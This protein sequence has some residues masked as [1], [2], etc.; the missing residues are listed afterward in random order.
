MIS[1]FSLSL[2]L[3]ILK[4]YAW[5]SAL[6][7]IFYILVLWILT[8]FT[9]FIPQNFFFITLIVLFLFGFVGSIAILIFVLLAV[10]KPL[11]SSVKKIEYLAKHSS[12]DIMST[13]LHLMQVEDKEGDDEPVEF[14]DLNKNLNF[15]YN[16]IK[17]KSLSLVREKAELKAITDAVS[18]A[19]IAIDTSQKVIFSNPQSEE[20]F[21]IKN[22]EKQ[23]YI[24]DIIQSRKILS[25]CE[26]CLASGVSSNLELNLSVGEHQQDRLF[27]VTISPLIHTEKEIDGAI[28]VCFDIT[29]IKNTEKS[30]I[31]FVSNVS[32][33]LKTPLTAIKGF[34]ETMTSDLESKNY[35][36]IYHFLNIVSRNVTRLIHLIDDL[37]SLSHIDSVSHLTKQE[38]NTRE[39][40]AVACETIHT[41]KHH[42][43]YTYKADTVLAERQWL[44]QVLY[45]LVSNA[46]KYTPPGS[47]IDIVWEKHP[48][49][50]LLTVKDDGEGIPLQ[51]QNRIFERF[52]RVEEDRSRDKGGT[53]IGLAIVKQVMEKHGGNVYLTSR[54]R[55][56]G[57]KLT[58]TFPR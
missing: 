22:F 54:R 41:E 37:L 40:T 6:C 34:V 30:H 58:C 1:K 50:V 47:N 33:E 12:D 10:L 8:Q 4:K 25:A 38:V 20:L 23:V 39:V 44:E 21:L 35:D 2:S 27:E 11:S 49:F 13:G 7:F 57:A 42:I 17:E 45:N 29:E 56:K 53:G 26:K 55:G 24:S 9:N 36:Q 3:W 46:V 16:N 31:D 15:I 5:I 52:Y 14:H 48:H 51:H 32:H 28:L 18:D 19:T 43:H